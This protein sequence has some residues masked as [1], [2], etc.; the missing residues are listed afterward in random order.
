MAWVPP[1]SADTSPPV[2][3]ILGPDPVG[4]HT[5]RWVY[6]TARF[7]DPD[8][9][10]ASS[11]SGMLDG[12]PVYL[13]AYPTDANWTDLQV[14]GGSQAVA[15]GLHTAQVSA[16]D[17]FGNGPTVL[18][19]SFSVDAFPPAVTI[20][21]PIGDPLIPDGSVTLAWTGTD[22]ASG[23]DH[24]AVRLDGGPSMNVGRATSFPF[25]G[26]PPGI[27]Y[28]YIVAYDKAGNSN[29]YGD[30]YVAMATVPVPPPATPPGNVTNATNQVTV[31]VSGEVPPWAVALLAVN[32][33][34]AAVVVAVLALLP[35]GGA[36]RRAWR[37]RVG[38]R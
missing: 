28:F 36:G 2:G 18:S 26:L 25:H 17:R 11:I 5:S 35:R 7:T 19:W 29:R 33:L 3:Y 30:D 1:A 12:R 21:S 15:D 14:S 37:T 6:L 31:V 9:I 20:T 16:S 10:L 38:R 8:G 23:V 34:E 24:Y 4:W 27:H 13:S 32:V 22:N